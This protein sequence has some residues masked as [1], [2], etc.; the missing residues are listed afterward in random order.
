MLL[1]EQ[2]HDIDGQACH[3][4]GGHQLV[5]ADFS[6]VAEHGKRELHGFHIVGMR[7]HQGPGVFV[8]SAGEFGDAQRG[9]RRAA[10]GHIDA[11]EGAQPA[12][13]VDAGRVVQRGGE[14]DVELPHQKHAKG[15]RDIGQNQPAVGVHQ[16]G[17]ALAEQVVPSGQRHGAQHG[18]HG[19]HRDLRGDHQSCQ[20]ERQHRG[21]APEADARQRV[22]RHGIDRQAEHQRPQRD[23]G[24]VEQV[25]APIAILHG[26]HIIVPLRLGGEEH[27]RGSV[28]LAVGLQGS[29]NRYQQRKSGGNQEQQNDHPRKY[30]E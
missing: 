25:A 23:I 2:E 9:E 29:A 17:A 6:F 11:Q 22:A 1:R 21:A 8:P 28:Y 16:P 24:A 30:F 26:V 14:A 12:A 4:R 5:P 15:T 19:D 20:R 10:Q 3:Q 27:R 18:E 13:A 7:H